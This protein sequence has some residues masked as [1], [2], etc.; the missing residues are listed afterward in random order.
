MN[1][2]ITVDHI[3]ANDINYPEPDIEEYFF[4]DSFSMNV[5]DEWNY[6]DEITFENSVSY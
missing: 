4:Q 5:E 2:S 3:E 1:N 6:F